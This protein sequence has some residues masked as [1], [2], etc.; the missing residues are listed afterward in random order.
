[1][2]EMSEPL[3]LIISPAVLKK[4]QEIAEKRGISLEDLLLLCIS[5]FI[6]REGG[7]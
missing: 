6:Q 5:E 4:L 2:K 3:E 1:M 7:E